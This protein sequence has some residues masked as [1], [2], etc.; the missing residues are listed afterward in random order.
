ML[1]IDPEYV[2]S[3]EFRLPF[4]RADLFN[5]TAAAQRIVDYWD[6]K[7]QLFGVEK[8]LKRHISLLD[9]K[10]EDYEA[11]K[12]SGVQL[13]PRVDEAGRAIIFQQ[14]KYSP[15]T[16]DSMHRLQWYMVHAAIFDSVRERSTAIQKSGFVYLVMVGDSKPVTCGSDVNS[17]IG[18]ESWTELRK[19]SR[20]RKHHTEFVL[21]MRPPMAVHCFI[22]NKWAM[23]LIERVLDIPGEIYRAKLCIYYNDS[24]REDASEMVEDD[25][26]EKE[27]NLIALQSYGIDREIIPTELGGDFDHDAQTFLMD[28]LQKDLALAGMDLDSKPGWENKLPSGLRDLLHI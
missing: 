12:L 20:S 6:H 8:G 7:V 25:Y 15:R 19:Y 1:F 21:P 11:L 26:G 5:V 2:E 18:F 17:I 4:L 14:L 10:E 28:R 3:E 24:C 16:A 9:L 27:A 23:A 22:C 13:L